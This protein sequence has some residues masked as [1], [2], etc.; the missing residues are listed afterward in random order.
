MLSKIRKCFDD[1]RV[2]YTSH[3]RKEMNEEEFGKIKENEVFEAIQNG[4]IIEDYSND[5]PYPSVL[6][7]R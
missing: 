3:A 2:L 4:E 6:V 5:K 7:Y 1:Y